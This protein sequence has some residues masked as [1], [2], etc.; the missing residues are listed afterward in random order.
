MDFFTCYVKLYIHTFIFF[1]LSTRNK[2]LLQLLVK[3]SGKYFIGY[4]YNDYKV[5]PLHTVV[6]KT[7]EYVKTYKLNGCIF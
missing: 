7:S 4:L 1:F 5:K 3:K 6:P 2:V